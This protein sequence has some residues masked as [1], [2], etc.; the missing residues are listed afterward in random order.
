MGKYFIVTPINRRF[1]F[2]R[3]IFYE[4]IFANASFATSKA[5]ERATIRGPSTPI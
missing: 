3:Q 2:L 4:I 5:L 1:I